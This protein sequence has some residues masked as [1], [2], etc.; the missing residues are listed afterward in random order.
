LAPA[1]CQKGDLVAVLAG[2][3]VPYILQPKASASISPGEDGNLGRC[4]TVLGDAYIHG[5]MDGEAL[6][7]VEQRGGEMEE[8]IL[9]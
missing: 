9:V 4:Y 3:K 8:I 1:Q 2:G 6:K 5:I 7:E